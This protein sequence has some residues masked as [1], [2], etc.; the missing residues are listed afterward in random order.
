MT[1]PIVEFAP[2][3]LERGWMKVRFLEPVYDGDDIVVQATADAE[4]INV[5][6]K[7]AD[8]TLCAIGTAAIPEM[9]EP[10]VDRYPEH[11]LPADRPAPSVENLIPGAPLGTV[12]DTI[13]AAEPRAVLQFS[14]EMLVRNFKL[15]PWIHT[16][17]EIQNSGLVLPGDKI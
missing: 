17:S 16:G 4:S 11:P 13:E 14:N 2:E 9:V 15:G 7:R 10:P 1:V 5:T 6:A 8:G 3:W 12:R